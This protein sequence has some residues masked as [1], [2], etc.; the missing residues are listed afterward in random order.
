LFRNL[1]LPGL[2]T[3]RVYERGITLASLSEFISRSQCTLQE[4]R[5]DRSSGRLSESIYREAL[6]SIATIVLEP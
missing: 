5:V 2:L 6:P 3:L 1:T 4:L